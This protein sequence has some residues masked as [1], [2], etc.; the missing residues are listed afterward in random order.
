MNVFWVIVIFGEEGGEL[1]CVWGGFILFL[2]SEG[3]R[4][5]QCVFLYGVFDCYV[6]ICDWYL[7]IRGIVLNDYV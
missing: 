1:V 7:E 2:F 4:Y 3:G 5:I 6:I